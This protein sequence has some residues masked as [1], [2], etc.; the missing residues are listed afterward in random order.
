MAETNATLKALAVTFK[1]RSEAQNFRGKKRDD[2]AVEFFAGAYGALDA[3]KHP[4][5]QAV[6]TTTMLFICTR[7]YSEVVRIANGQG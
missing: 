5:A 6:G 7:G 2:L 4:D 1:G 3:V